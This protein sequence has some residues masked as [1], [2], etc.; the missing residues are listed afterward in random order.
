M[1]LIAPNQDY[2]QGPFFGILLSSLAG[3]VIYTIGLLMS[4]DAFPE[5]RQALAGSVFNVF[6]MLGSS[7]GLTLLDVIMAAVDGN[8]SRIEQDPQTQ[9]RGLRISFWVL[10]AMA[11]ASA[12]LGGYGLRKVGRI[13]QKRSDSFRSAR[14][15]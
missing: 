2:W 12:I 15:V 7:I 4:A 3:D 6:Y 10:F 11:V 9:M 14:T 5:Q 8:S 13:G 1:A